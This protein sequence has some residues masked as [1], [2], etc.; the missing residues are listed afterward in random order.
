MMQK[1]MLWGAFLCLIASASWGAMFPVANHA[2]QYIDPFWFTIV[3]YAPVTILLIVALFI[4]EG[5][6]AFRTNGQGLI[7]WFFGTMGFVVYN[8]LIFVG[9]DLLGEPGV[10]LASIME[11]LAP[12]LSVLIVWLIHKNSP[13]W[14]TLFCIIGAFIGV[15]LVVSNGDLSILLGSNRLFPL[16]LLLLAA[17]GWAFYTIGGGHFSGWSVLRYSTLSCLY[18]TVTATIVVLIGSMMGL[19]EVPTMTILYHVRYDMLFMIFV[20]GL[21][22]LIGWNKG[23]SILKPINAILFINFAPVTTLIIRLIQGHTISTYEFIGVSLVCM[24]IIANNMYQ[25]METRKSYTTK[26]RLAYH[27]PQ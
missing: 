15:F 27:S 4:K 18:G 13:K 10:L 17:L 5:K 7:L 25:R 23:V 14:F 12:I 11:A 22:A 20:P 2:F 26:K 19:I 24:M 16:F 1:K 6:Q 9:Q 3:R 8:L 21:I